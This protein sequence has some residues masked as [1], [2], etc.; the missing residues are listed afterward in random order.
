[1][2]NFG[3]WLAICVVSALAFIAWIVYTVISSLATLGI[4]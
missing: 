3:K 2:F 1:M 4:A